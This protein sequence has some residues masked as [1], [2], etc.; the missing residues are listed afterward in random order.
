[1]AMAFRDELEAQIPAMRRYARAL[2]RN[3]E[4]ADDLVQEALMRAL[5]AEPRWHA[6]N[7]R[8]WLFTILTNLNRNRLRALGRRAPHEGIEALDSLHA[9]PAP[10]GEAR[11]IERALDSLS[12]DQRE[13]LLLVALEGLSYA[14]CAQILSVPTGTVMSRLSRARQAMRQALDTGK[15]PASHLRL[16]K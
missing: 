4:T 15:A 13:V 9:T 14:D 3:R 10:S 7:V 16:V 1:M 12:T 5:D 8:S 11:D 2:A 6:G